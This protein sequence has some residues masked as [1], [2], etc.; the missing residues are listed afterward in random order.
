MDTR[1][2]RLTLGAFALAPLFA[3]AAPADDAPVAEAVRKIPIRPADS[4]EEIRRKLRETG[5][6]DEKIDEII[7]KMK[8]AFAK[9]GV[10]APAGTGSATA[11]P[12]TAPGAG[13]VPT[14]GAIPPRPPELNT[15]ALDS[16]AMESKDPALDADRKAIEAIKQEKSLLEAR[17]ALAETKRKQSLFPL[18]EEKKVLKD[19]APGKA[20]RGTGTSTLDMALRIVEFLAAQDQPL[21]LAHIAKAFSASKAT[22][23]RHL[24]TLQRHD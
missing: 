1:F 4:P 19:D 16:Q 5:M 17:I 6:P 24:V 7:A 13:S 10:T 3:S 12:V 22:V 8:G 14:S 20:E 23:Y 21:T 18:T 11:T 15:A 2:F 9:R